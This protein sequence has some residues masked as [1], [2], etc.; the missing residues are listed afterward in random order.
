MYRDA[1]APRPS[2]T[3]ITKPDIDDQQFFCPLPSC[4]RPLKLKFAKGG[5]HAHCYYLNIQSSAI[6]KSISGLTG[7]FSI[8]VLPL[9][10]ISPPLTSSALL[11]LRS[12]A[13]LED[14]AAVPIH[15]ARQPPDPETRF[16]SGLANISR[17]FTLADHPIRPP[18]PDAL[19]FL[20][21]SPSPATSAAILSPPSTVASTSDRSFLLIEF[22]HDSKPG[23][24]RGIQVPQGFPYWTRPG[25]EPYECYSADYST[26]M[27]VE[28][29]YIHNVR[30]PPRILVRSMGV[31]GSDEALHIQT[32]VAENARRADMNSP[33]IPPPFPPVPPTSSASGAPS[34]ADKGKG[35]KLMRRSGCDGHR[36]WKQLDDDDEV[37]IVDFRPAIKREA[38]T[39][40]PMCKPL[41]IHIPT[42]PSLPAL[43]SSTSSGPL[44]SAGP[45]TSALPSPD[46]PYFP[47][48]L[49][50]WRF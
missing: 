36:K 27:Q 23:V 39:P 41:H 42:S 38:T 31:T 4:K 14:A 22:V 43:S 33:R 12:N 19:P 2:L 47:A 32:L 44:S 21:R 8:A 15:Q 7:I 9:A 34:A 5:E 30:K 35:K 26:W 16:F 11:A 29:C 1:S 49:D 17:S 3:S 50:A 46:S 37:L 10:L 45:S 13:S 28:A 20:L 6:T 25:T 18:S 24:P 48:A 40:P